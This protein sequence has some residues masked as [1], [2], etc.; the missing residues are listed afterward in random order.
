MSAAS[1]GPG[2]VTTATSRVV[3][4]GD[5]ASAGP[6]RGGRP[7][8]SS[9]SS[10]SSGTA[11]LV[12]AGTLSLLGYGGAV[13]LHATGRSSA[14]FYLAMG[15][16][17]LGMVVAWV[18]APRVPRRRVLIAVLGGAALF[19]LVL[20]PAAPA[21]SDD[22]YRYLWDGAV[23]EAGVNPYVHAPDA[24]ALEGL[25]DGDVW[26]RINRR[27]V[28]TIYPGG[29]QAVFLG[30]RLVGVTRPVA[31]KALFVVVDLLA[32]LLLVRILARGGRRP[33]SALLYAWNPLVVLAVAG[34]GHVDVLAVLAVLAA[35][36]AWQSRRRLAVGLWLGV[37][38]AVKLYPLLLLPAFLRPRDAPAG[39]VR[40]AW[41]VPVGALGVLAVAELPY[42]VGAGSEVLGFLTPD[43]Y[44]AQ[45]GYLNGNRLIA[46]QALGLPRWPLTL[47]VAV[48]VAGW[49]VV[50]RGSAAARA[51]A[52][53]GAALLLTVP[54]PWYALPLVALAAA[55]GPGLVSGRGATAADAPDLLWPLFA[56]GLQVVHLS[57]WHPFGLSLDAGRYVLIGV[58]AVAAGAAVVSGQ[59][60]ASVG[61]ASL[62]GRGP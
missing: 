60:I 9:G 14:V 17:S 55:G 61:A 59:R 58:T 23:Q 56:V 2:A 39:W 18:V 51:A 36:A 21:L 4:H 45:E 54:Y 16:G 25:R 57:W 46:A 37:G 26:P 29:A 43:G 1:D 34:S 35:V 42:L 12:G 7:S 33:R 47:A 5:A 52:L 48:A 15:L 44:L 3:A 62:W 53:L 38:A 49:A 24:P 8:A 10:E 41:I 28:P 13:W 19:R 30:M 6:G 20:V 50:A 22:L 40:R 27:S 11:A 31:L 32:V